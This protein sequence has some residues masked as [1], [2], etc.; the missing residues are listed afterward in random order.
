MMSPRCDTSHEVSG[1]EYDVGGFDGVDARY[2]ELFAAAQ[3]VLGSDVRV[4]SVAAGGSIASGTA[5]R[6]SD[7]DLVVV[8]T[9]DGF[10][11]LVA[12]WPSWLA[13]ITPTVFARTPIAPSLINT[14]TTDGLA[15]D[16]AIHKGSVFDF[17]RPSGWFAGGL[18]HSS[19]DAAL[20]YSVAELLRGLCG[21]FI[22]LVERGEHLRH[23]T[24]GLPHLLG[25][26][27]T[28]FLAEL[29]APMPAKLWSDV[30]TDDQLAAVDAL[31]AISTTRE[32]VIAFGLAL[33]ELMLTRARPEFA[34][35]DLRWPSEFAATT[36]R[37]VRLA[38]DIDCSAWLF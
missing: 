23:V 9:D 10:D 6:W 37:R 30:Y 20:E 25:L 11:S 35:R 27:T 3:R 17:A 1:W 29:D 5:D 36:A 8:A 34:R 18:H 38:L 15:F 28:V 24:T 19:L 21:P 4:L 2:V 13:A 14:V 16:I 7:L 22:S 12:D 32:S 26:L 33:G 31:P